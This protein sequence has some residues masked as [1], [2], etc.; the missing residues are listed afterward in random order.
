MEENIQFDKENEVI[1]LG[2]RKYRRYA[3]PEG[4]FLSEDG[5]K[6][7]EMSDQQNKKGPK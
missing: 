6:E 7:G 1:P 5:R 3:L 4:S 2:G